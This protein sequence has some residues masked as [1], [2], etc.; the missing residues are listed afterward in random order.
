MKKIVNIPWKL[1]S[2][3]FGAVDFFGAEKILYYLQKNVTKRSRPDELTIS[4]IWQDHRMYLQKYGL[5][6]WG[7][8]GAFSAPHPAFD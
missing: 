4:P 2:F 3:V 5:A 1:K 6:G 7:V 8:G